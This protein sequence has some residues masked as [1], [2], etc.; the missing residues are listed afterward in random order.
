MKNESDDDIRFD[1]VHDS[2][3]KKAINKKLGIKELKTEIKE[4]IGCN[5]AHFGYKTTS[6]LKSLC[7][8]FLFFKWK[9]LRNNPSMRN[10]LFY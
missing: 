8:C 1:K 2:Y 6:I 10:F 5:K 3:M 9:T 7:C 4:V